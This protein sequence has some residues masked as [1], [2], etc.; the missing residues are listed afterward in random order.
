[1]IHKSVLPRP[2]F[3]VRLPLSSPSL[4]ARG[5][6]PPLG[7]IHG[8][9]SRV[10]PMS[11]SPRTSAPILMNR[12]LAVPSARVIRAIQTAEHLVAPCS[13]F[14]LAWVLVTRPHEPTRHLTR[15]RPP[16]PC[17]IQCRYVAGGKLRTGVPAQDIAL[18]QIA[19][20]A[21][22]TASAASIPTASITSVAGDEIPYHGGMDRDGPA[23]FVAVESSSMVL[24]S[25]TDCSLTRATRRLPSLQGASVPA[26]GTTEP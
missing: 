16:A 15:R 20:M 26:K 1:M 24:A 17:P 3:N 7:T 22:T 5:T 8:G 2:T 6:P 9:L 19:G 25:G 14:A 11:Q 13:A 4:I 12:Y 10:I 23:L 18:S 21:T